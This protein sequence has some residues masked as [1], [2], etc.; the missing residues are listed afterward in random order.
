MIE[1]QISETQKQRAKA[2]YPFTSLNGSITS[3][4]SNIYGAIGEVVIFDYFS[5]HTIDHRATYDYDMVIDGYT[6]D[7][8]TKHTTVKPKPN[9]NCSISAFNT[10]Q[11]C[12][13]YFFCRAL[14]DLSKIY[15]LGYIS[16]IKFFQSAT[17]NKKGEY[18]ANG[19]YFKDDC[20]NLPIKYLHQF[21]SK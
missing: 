7:V 17:F 1:L 9:Y 5:N 18:D 16:K 20:Y 6:V 10:K 11:K 4:K 12:D 13:Y 2:L 8:K 19:F 21:T 15:L 14:K 3:G